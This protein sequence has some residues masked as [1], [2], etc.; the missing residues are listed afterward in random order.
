MPNSA[1]WRRRCLFTWKKRAWSAAL[2]AE[3]NHMTMRT[4]TRMICEW[5][6]S[7]DLDWSDFEKECTHY[8]CLGGG[9]TALI[10]MAAYAA[11]HCDSKLHPYYFLM[12]DKLSSFGVDNFWQSDIEISLGKRMERLPWNVVYASLFITSVKYACFSL[13]CNIT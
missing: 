9:V 3:E 1:V 12:S 11:I 7:I 8:G 4:T 13:V 6:R 5:S 10:V 2:Y